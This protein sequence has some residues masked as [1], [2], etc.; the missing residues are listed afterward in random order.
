MTRRPRSAAPEPNTVLTTSELA[1]WFKVSERTVERWG[2]PS[3]APGRYL[4]AHVL[5]WCEVRRRERAA[6]TTALTPT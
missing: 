4:F 1:T 3:V 5:D 6:V 2:I